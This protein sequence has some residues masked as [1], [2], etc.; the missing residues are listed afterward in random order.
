A[1][2]GIHHEA[3]LDVVDHAD[4]MRPPFGHVV[5][6]AD[7]QTGRLHALGRT[8][9]GYDLEAQ[10]DQLA[11][12]VRRG[13]LGILTHA[14]AH[15]APGRPHFAGAQLGFGEGFG[16]AVAHTHHLTGGLHFRPENGVD[17]REL[18][19]G[20]Y[21]FLH[22]EEGRN[23]F[24]GKAQLLERLAGHDP[25]GNL[26][27]GAAD[28]LGDEGHGTRSTRVHFNHIDGVA[29]QRQ[30]HVHQTD[31]AQL[32]RHALD[33]VTHAILHVGRQRVRRQRTGR[34]AGMHACL[35]DMLHDRAD[36]HIGAIGHRVHVDLDGA[37][38]EVVQQHRTVI[39]DFHRIAQVALEL[40]F[41]IDDLHGAATQYIGRTHHQRIADLVRR[42]NGFVFAAHG[43]VRRL[44]QVQALDHLLEALAV[45]GTVDGFRA[46]TDDRHARLF[47]RARQFQRGLAA[48]LDD[49]TL[50][51]FDADD[52]Q[53]VFQG[54]RLEVQAIGSVVVGRDGFRVA[55]DH[56]GLIAIFTH[57]QCCMHAAV[58]KL[59]A[60]A[61]TVRAT[62]QYHDLV[63]AGRIGLALFFIGRVHVGGVGGELGGAG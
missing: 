12:H 35:F 18:G 26:R 23:H 43:G 49:H 27:Q 63:A 17:T 1:L 52:F 30:L 29:L 61:D 34:V 20:E 8:C 14:D 10:L 6:A 15:S 32:Q 56:D 41:L 16:E 48:V 39:G 62:A 40:V 31:H 21:R 33:L 45:F 44:T 3:D 37:V 2:G 58:V 42:G 7:R 4:D 22:C 36:H 50:G 9:G 11:S 60:L 53:Y 38:E 55:V 13:R 46:G 28:A 51:L 54:D 19:E 24:L 5:H 57:G 59:D 47:Q 25:S